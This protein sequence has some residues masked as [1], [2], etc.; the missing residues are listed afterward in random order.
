METF[1][2][3]EHQAA[4]VDLTDIAWRCQTEALQRGSMCSG[5][6]PNN[7][8]PSLSELRADSLYLQKHTKWQQDWFILFQR[9]SVLCL[10]TCDIIRYELGSMQPDIQQRPTWTPSRAPVPSHYRASGAKT[11][12]RKSHRIPWIDLPQ[13]A[14][15]GLRD[16][17]LSLRCTQSDPGRLETSLLQTYANVVKPKVCQHLHEMMSLQIWLR[18]WTANTAITLILLEMRKYDKWSCW[19]SVCVWISLQSLISWHFLRPGDFIGLARI[20]NVSSHCTRRWKAQLWYETAFQ[21]GC[22]HSA[23]CPCIVCACSYMT[24]MLSTNRWLL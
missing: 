16:G 7:H 15:P 23:V 17:L 8:Q 6:G 21:C 1:S 20:N 9:F 24:C 4:Q 3:M 13:L 2:W 11:C 14:S 5:P 22:M 10:D 18:W 19:C 12:S